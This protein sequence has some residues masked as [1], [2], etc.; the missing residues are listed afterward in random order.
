MSQAAQRRL[1]IGVL[2]LGRAFTVML[3]TFARDPRIA[4]VAAADPRADARARFAQEFSSR[5]Y[6]NAE[7]LCSDPE[8]DV[9]YIATPHQY[10]AS[11]ALLAAKNGKH[12]LVEKPMALTLDDCLALTEA[13]RSA[14]VQLVVGHS[15]SF[16]APIARARELIQSGEFG[17]VR[18]ITAF[19]YTDYLYRLRR[20]EELDSAAGGGAIWNQAAHQVDIVRL[21]GGGLVK[22]V[23][24]ASGAWD[25]ARPTEGAYGALLRFENGCFATLSYSGYGNF[26]SDEFQNWIGEMGRPKRPN[27]ARKVQPFLRPAEEAAAKNARNYGG[28]DYQLAT[29]APVAHQHFGTIVVSCDGADLRPVPN[30]VVIYKNGERR[31]DELVPPIIPRREVVDELTAAVIS[32]QKPLHDGQWAAATLEVCL[33]MLESSHTGRE[34]AL[35]HQVASA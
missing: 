4:L 25:R 14:G 3:P 11:Q 2:G 22:S 8:V 27:S 33:A 29:D 7:A 15:H 34:V 17:A 31:L 1:R 28:P 26:D 10:H 5:V 6:D 21:I 35:K 30:G 19:N 12:L 20:P 16:D 13:A 32:G 18:M 23:H 9:V 24:A